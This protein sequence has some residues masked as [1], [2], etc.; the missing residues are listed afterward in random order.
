MTKLELIKTNIKGN[1]V[2]F[3]FY[4]KDR[5]GYFLQ[6]RKVFAIPVTLRFW[7]D[8]ILFIKEI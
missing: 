8:T 1:K 6:V 4:L 5:P 3:G 2:I 7:L